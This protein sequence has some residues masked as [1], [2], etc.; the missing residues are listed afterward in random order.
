MEASMAVN[1][2]TQALS[3]A[4]GL[5][6]DDFRSAVDEADSALNVAEGH[7][8]ALR[9]ILESSRHLQGGDIQAKTA[10]VAHFIAFELEHYVGK[11]EAALDSLR[12]TYLGRAEH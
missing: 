1:G 5:H 12:Q 2:I 6:V 9:F 3:P 7:F 8:K 10:E 11:A 4:K